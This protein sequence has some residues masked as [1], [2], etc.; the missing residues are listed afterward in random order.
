M[1]IA[2]IFS[3]DIRARLCNS[4]RYESVFPSPST[5]YTKEVVLQND[6]TPSLKFIGYGVRNKKAQENNCF[7]DSENSAN[8]APQLYTVRTIDYTADFRN[9]ILECS[10]TKKTYDSEKPLSEDMRQ[11]VLTDTSSQELSGRLSRKSLFLPRKISRFS[12]ANDETIFSEESIDVPEYIVSIIN[13]KVSR[14]SMFKSLFGDYCCS[15]R[16]CHFIDKLN[17]AK[18]W[19]DFIVISSKA[20]I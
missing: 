19:E 16:D 11:N 12:F 18:T 14:F 5:I 13:K 6:P 15:S 10:S 7:Y 3:K 20:I 4:K 2:D 8:I 17:V 1:K 9:T